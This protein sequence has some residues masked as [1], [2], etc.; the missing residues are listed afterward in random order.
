M[1]LYEK[2]PLVKKKKSEQSLLLG[3]KYGTERGP[4]EHSEVMEIFYAL[5]EVW[6]THPNG[7]IFLSHAFQ[8]IQNFTL[9]NN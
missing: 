8:H 2:E 9:K 3:R 1:R 4:K 6:V 7:G 5:I